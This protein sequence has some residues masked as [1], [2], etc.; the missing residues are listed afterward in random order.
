MGEKGGAAM[1]DGQGRETD[2]RFYAPIDFEVVWEEE[3]MLRSKPCPKCAAVTDLDKHP[4]AGIH[5]NKLIMWNCQC[6]TTRMIPIS[7][8]V[9][10]SIVRR[11]L[12]AQQLNDYMDGRVNGKFLE[13][14]ASF[15]P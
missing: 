5:D 8:H 1:S 2:D 3:P 4:L 13:K 9:P 7:H 14:G 10:Q 12:D 6:G 15:S 11:A